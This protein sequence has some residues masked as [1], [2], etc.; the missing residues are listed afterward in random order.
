MTDVPCQLTWD[1]YVTAEEP[2]ITDD[3]PPGATDTD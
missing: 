3:L 2:I 1:V